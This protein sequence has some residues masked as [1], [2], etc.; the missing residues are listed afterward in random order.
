MAWKERAAE[1]PAA[2]SRLVWTVS[3]TDASSVSRLLFI[4]LQIFV[5]F[6]QESSRLDLTDSG[7]DAPLGNTQMVDVH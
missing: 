3:C 7:P 6:M 4:I 5:V 1:G 2:Q